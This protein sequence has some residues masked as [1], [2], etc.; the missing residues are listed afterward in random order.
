[1]SREGRENRPP[2]SSGS[3]ATW[4]SNLASIGTGAEVA[5]EHLDTNE[6]VFFYCA[7]DARTTVR[8]EN[9]TFDADV[10]R[11]FVSRSK[12]TIRAQPDDS[13]ADYTCE[14]RH[15]APKWATVAL[16]HSM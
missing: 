16:K 2:R 1:M 13:D 12:L 9:T 8:V 10:P 4:K 15:Q 6:S 7:V 5:I 14:A 3:S 11:Q